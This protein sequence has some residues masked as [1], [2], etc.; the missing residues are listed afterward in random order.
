MSAVVSSAPVIYK[1]A[2][3]SDDTEYSQLLPNGTK[4]F[5]IQAREDFDVRVAFTDGV[6]ASGSDYITIKSG[7][8][9]SSYQ[10]WGSAT[11]TIYIAHTAGE[12]VNAELVCWR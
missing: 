5:E 7:D 4:H 10:L 8:A 11:I 3:A 1:V 9:Y 12:T 2:M 6:V